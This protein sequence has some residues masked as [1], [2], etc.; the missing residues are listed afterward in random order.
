MAIFFMGEEEVSSGQQANVQRSTLN[1]ST[2][3]P[4]VREAAE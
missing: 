4:R 1:I 3:T 2:V